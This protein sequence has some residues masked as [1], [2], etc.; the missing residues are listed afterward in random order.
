[1]LTVC[2][3]LKRSLYDLKEVPSSVKVRNRTNVIVCVFLVD[4]KKFQSDSFVPRIAALWNIL[5]DGSFSNHYNLDH[6]KSRV[7]T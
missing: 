1:M 7:I 6:L 2:C 4:S 3:M 5:S